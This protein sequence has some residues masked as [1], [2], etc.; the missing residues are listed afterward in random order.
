MSSRKQAILK[1]GVTMWPDVS[2]RAIARELHT[3]HSAVLY[4][5]GG[6]AALRDAVAI[7][8]VRVGDARVVPMLIVTGHAAAAELD[9]GE[10]RRWLESAA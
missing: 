6:A 5:F 9:A 2:A 3:A 4:H 10:R 7:E 1:L 8:A